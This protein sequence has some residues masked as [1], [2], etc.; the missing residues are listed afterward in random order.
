M[1]TKDNSLQPGEEKETIFK[2]IEPNPCGD[3]SMVPLEQ[4]SFTAREK[5]NALAVELRPESGLTLQGFRRF[6]I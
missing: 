5:A 3:W 2:K 1:I 4:A 6:Y